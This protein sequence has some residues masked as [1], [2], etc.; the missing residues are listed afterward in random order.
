[1]PS[2]TVHVKTEN[3]IHTSISTQDMLCCN[4][5]FMALFLSKEEVPQR[6]DTNLFIFLVLGAVLV[7]SA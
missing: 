7:T 4:Y 5:L 3:Y 1:M 6:L 2:I